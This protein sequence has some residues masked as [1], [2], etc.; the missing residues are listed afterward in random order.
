[1]TQAAAQ[2]PLIQQGLYQPGQEQYQVG[3][4]QQQQQQN[5][6]NAPYNALSWYS[7]LLGLNGSS[8]GGSSSSNNGAAAT[9]D[10]GMGLAAAGTAAE[11]ASL[12]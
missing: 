3:S 7:G 4:T 10:A 11:L 9:Q 12:Y 1:M 6:I 8:M 2:S 5:V